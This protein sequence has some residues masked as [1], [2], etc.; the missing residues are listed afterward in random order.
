MKRHLVTAAFLMAALLC[1]AI[2]S[3]F[4][5]IAFAVAGLVLE[6]VFWFRL[7]QRRR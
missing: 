4:G 5:V 6:V 7:I 2:G 3:N 1:Y